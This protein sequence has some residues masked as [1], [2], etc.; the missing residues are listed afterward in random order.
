[1]NGSSTTQ[2]T[3]WHRLRTLLLHNINNTSSSSQVPMFRG[4]ARSHSNICSKSRRISSGSSRSNNNKH[5]H[6]QRN[7]IIEASR[8]L[9]LRRPDNSQHLRN[10]LP[11]ILY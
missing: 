2:R 7:S 9:S 3:E 6:H 8:V 1:V 5:I 10:R 11:Q 4:L